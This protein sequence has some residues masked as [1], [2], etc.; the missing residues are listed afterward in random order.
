MSLPKTIE[1]F[2]LPRNQTKV[3]VIRKG[4]IT[5]NQKCIFC[6][7]WATVSKVMGIYV[8]FYHDQQPNMVRSRDSGCKF[9]KF[10]FLA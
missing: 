6:W 1:K 7:I 3:Y 5:A 10:L 9:P 8:K 4:L 2:G